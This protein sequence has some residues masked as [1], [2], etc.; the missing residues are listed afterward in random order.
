MRNPLADKC[1]IAHHP[2]IG[3]V[4]I[5]YPPKWKLWRRRKWQDVQVHYTTASEP[6]RSWDVPFKDAGGMADIGRLGGEAAVVAYCE[7]YGT[8]TKILP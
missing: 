4:C 3:T 7:I 6:A 2:Q 1:M 8:P 5:H